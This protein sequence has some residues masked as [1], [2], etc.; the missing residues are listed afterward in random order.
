[1]KMNELSMLLDDL[2]DCGNKMIATA[3]A[4]KQFY[5][6][7]DTPA[8]VPATVPEAPK[9]PEKKSFSKEE[10]RAALARKAQENGSVN[11]VQ[12]K[13]LVAK[14][15]TDNSLSGVPKNQY[16]ALMSELEAM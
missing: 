6:S 11:K 10:V 15:S 3:E 9:V 2:I 4:L 5:S 13:N 12:V 14:Y 1:M 7:D 16:E 8:E